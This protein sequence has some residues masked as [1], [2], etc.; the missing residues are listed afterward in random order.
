MELILTWTGVIGG[1]LLLALSAW[2]SSRKRPDSLR[3][4]LIPWRLLVL[5]SGA[6]IL[7]AGVHLLSLAGLQRPGPT[8]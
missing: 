2:Q 8:Y 6:V 7:L 5:L 3:P 4:R 1:G